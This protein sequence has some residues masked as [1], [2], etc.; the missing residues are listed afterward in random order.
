M[1]WGE[2]L[3]NWH[4][5]ESYKKSYAANKNMGGGVALTLSHD[6]DLSNYLFGKI[7]KCYQVKNKTNILKIK[8]E[9]ITD[10]L[11]IH[12]KNIIGNIH[13][14]YL[15]KKPER[16][17]K[18]YGTDGVLEMNYYN[19]SLKICRK[20]KVSTLKFNNFERNQ[21]FIKEM[22]YFFNCIKNKVNPRPN[23]NDSVYLLNK[24]NLI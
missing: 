5:K 2:F 19:N 16:F 17:I 10:F 7:K 13:L 8:A 14:D 15:Q 11:L 6:L 12:E 9:E 24:T 21:L 20:N 23:L 3:P 4:K 1:H 18:I 22:K